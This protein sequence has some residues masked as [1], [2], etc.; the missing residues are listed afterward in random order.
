MGYTLLILVFENP[1]VR[2]ELFLTRSCHKTLHSSSRTHTFSCQTQT[3]PFQKKVLFFSSAALVTLNIDRLSVK[4]WNSLLN[5]E[6]ET[7]R[8]LQVALMTTVF[9]WTDIFTISTAPAFAINT[10]Y[11]A[12]RKKDQASLQGVPSVLP[13][14]LWL[15]NLVDLI[16]PYLTHEAR[17]FSS[18]TD[19]EGRLRQDHEWSAC[20]L[21][22][23]LHQ[24]GKGSMSCHMSVCSVPACMLL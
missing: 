16:S 7:G 14:Y 4:F 8:S 9:N 6:R 17:D 23:S 13:I 19:W 22:K 3:F 5:K 1:S 24:V 10:V 12:R 20:T 2:Y 21:V 18:L 15:K 11:F